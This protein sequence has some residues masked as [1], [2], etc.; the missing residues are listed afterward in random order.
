MFI[1]LIP[2][3]IPLLSIT[4]VLFF[5][6]RKR[7]SSIIVLFIAIFLN[8]KTETYPIHINISNNSSHIT[9]TNSIKILTYNIGLHNKYIK[10]NEDSLIQLKN[11]FLQQ[12]AD[13]LI[14]PE[15]RLANKPKLLSI[16]N[17]L[18]EYNINADDNLNERY[19]ETFVFS[20]YPI[21]EAKCIG[22]YIYS[23]NISIDQYNIKLVACHLISNQWHSKLN[24]R[25][26]ILNNIQQGYYLRQKQAEDIC[27]SFKECK[28]PILICGDLNDISGSST[29]SILQNKLSLNDA[30][31]NAG[32]GYGSTFTGKNLFLRLDH[33]LYSKQYFDIQ[34]VEIPQVHFSDHKPLI[35]HLK[36]H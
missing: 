16:L 17:N 5:L 36:L 15:S 20:H 34:S 11:F 26:G 25:D 8:I 4:G 33:I 23:M 35:T 14:L 19:I 3:L 1:L 21:H 32:C 10:Q 29:L 6:F 24:G 22:D 28:E 12:N 27:E 31:W 9:N 13:I 18:Y 7:I 30:W 2:V